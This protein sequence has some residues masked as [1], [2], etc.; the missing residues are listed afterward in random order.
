MEN[1]YSLHLKEL[2]YKIKCAK[3]KDFPDSLL[4]TGTRNTLFNLEGLARLDSKKHKKMAR[5]LERF[6]KGEDLLGKLDFYL[7]VKEMVKKEKLNPAEKFSINRDADNRLKA[8]RQECEKYF[9]QKFDL[10]KWTKKIL[11][12]T[13]KLDLNFDKNHLEQIK[14]SMVQEIDSLHEFL[15]ERN[16]TF[17]LMEE[18]VHE[19]R[20][21]IRWFSIYAWALK[22]MIALK[23]KKIFSPAQKKYWIKPKTLKNPFINI[24]VSNEKNK[25]YFNKEVFLALSGMIIDVGEIKDTGLLNEHLNTI[26]K[27]P[28]HHPEKQLKEINGMLK[29]YKN[30]NLF[31]KRLFYI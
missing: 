27:K 16:Y 9:D 19:F 21:D 30:D 1:L 12:R 18:E 29:K 24:P 11:K 5:W 15:E 20:R 31:L 6:K 14:E 25:I 8:I 3:K 4:K 23:D 10:E 26:L 13:E 2:S 17:T 7:W 28:V 22:G